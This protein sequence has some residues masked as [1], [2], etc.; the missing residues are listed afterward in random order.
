[1][2]KKVKVKP[3]IELSIKKEISRINLFLKK[4]RIK[5]I[6]DIDIAFYNCCNERFENDLF[7]YSEKEKSIFFQKGVKKF[8]F[9]LT[10]IGTHDIIALSRMQENAELRH[11]SEKFICIYRTSE[12]SIILHQD[13]SGSKIKIRTTIKINQSRI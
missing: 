4:K 9:V 5:L 6:G 3:Y 13:F 8:Q 11:S 2:R 7:T 12:E 10:T 1:M